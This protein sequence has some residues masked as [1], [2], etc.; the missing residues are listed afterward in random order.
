MNTSRPVVIFLIVCISGLALFPLSG[1][2]FYMEL[3]IHLMVMG[4]FAMSLDLLIGYTGL[5]SFGHAAF[6]GLAGYG[7]AIVTPESEAISIWISLP[8]CLALTAFV[9]LIIGWFSVRTTGIYFIMITLAFAQMLFYYFNENLE[10]GGSDGI[11]IFTKPLVN[12]GEYQLLDL[13]NPNSLYYLVLVSLIG[14]YVL[15]ATFLKAPYGQVIQAIR[16]NEHR[17]KALGY[18][19]FR[20]KLVTF[21]IAGTLAGFAGYLEA[22]STGIVSPGH[23]NW[24]NSGLVMMLVILGGMGT[25]YGPVLGA[26]VLGILHDQAQ[27]LTE[28]WH[29]VQG[30]FVIL[31]VLFL[32]HGI[33]GV[34][35]GKKAKS[36]AP[37]EPYAE[38]DEGEPHER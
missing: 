20:Y 31:I 29:L 7:L 28:H 26:F 27:D 25:L 23:L 12:I 17:T 14:C 30:I 18:N 16:A 8:A 3:A 32:P 24:H 4:I 19:T 9:A 37:D 15:L 6:F 21:V 2:E 5:V 38:S 34:L 22:I 10:L 11:F 35:K 1:D 33:A 13:N 36:T